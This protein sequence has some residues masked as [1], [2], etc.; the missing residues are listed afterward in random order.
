MDILRRLVFHR[1]VQEFYGRQNLLNGVSV[2]LVEFLWIQF[3]TGVL[4]EEDDGLFYEED[5]VL[6]RLGVL[7]I[8]EG[9]RLESLD[10][11]FQQF[12]NQ[13]EIRRSKV[14]DGKETGIAES[15]HHFAEICIQ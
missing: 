7:R 4:E 11:P 12:G 8:E 3:E 2:G 15:A 13:G 1:V 5:P 6:F 14:F 9:I 10:Y